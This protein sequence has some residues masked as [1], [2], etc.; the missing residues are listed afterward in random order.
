MAST[1]LKTNMSANGLNT[2]L[3]IIRVV[4]GVTMLI[5]G[6]D[7]LMGFAEMS[8]SPFWTQQVNFLGMGGKVSLALVIFAEFF[9]AL[10]LILG[11]FTRPAL[12][13]LIFCMAYAWLVTHKAHVFS[14]N[15]KGHIEGLE[16]AFQYLLVYIALLFTGPGKFSVDKV[17]FK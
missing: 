2:A 16:S 3:L 15:D 9:C 8:A 7:K 4:F 1:L 13:V 14:K 10:F 6:Y 11:I 17:L 5:H 12:A